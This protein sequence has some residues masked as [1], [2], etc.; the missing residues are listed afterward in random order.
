MLA[1]QLAHLHTVVTTVDEL[2]HPVEAFLGLLYLGYGVC[3]MW[4]SVESY[5]IPTN[6]DISFKTIVCGVG[7]LLVSFQGYISV[8]KENKRCLNL[9]CIIAGTLIAAL[10]LLVATNHQIEQ[11]F[12]MRVNK[13]CNLGLPMNHSLTEDAK[14]RKKLRL[15]FHAERALPFILSLFIILFV[16]ITPGAFFP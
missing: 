1:E 12:K 3:V 16:S 4:N 7:I 15:L 6:Y 5:I 14:C 9:Y 8:K 2:W 10:M 13:E 11:D